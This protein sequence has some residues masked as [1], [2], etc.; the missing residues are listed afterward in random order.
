MNSDD[1]TKPV[2]TLTLL[3]RVHEIARTL[4]V[5]LTD[6]KVKDLARVVS[7]HRF[8]DYAAGRDGKQQSQQMP[9]VKP[10]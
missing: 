9:A 6:E 2:L 4:G 7:Q 3:K 10:R 5:E 1:D 8:E